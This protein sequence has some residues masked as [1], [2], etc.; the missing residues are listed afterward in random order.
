MVEHKALNRDRSFSNS[1]QQGSKISGIDPQMTRIS[2]DEMKTGKPVC[3]EHAQKKLVSE[4][5]RVSRY[6]S[7]TTVLFQRPMCCLR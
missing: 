2:A 5:R 6:N 3:R 1:A 4:L 7:L